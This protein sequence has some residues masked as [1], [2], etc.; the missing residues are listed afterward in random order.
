M[1]TD[2]DRLAVEF[3]CKLLQSL[4]ASNPND[5]DEIQRVKKQIEELSQKLSG[6]SVAPGLRQDPSVPTISDPSK[7]DMEQ[8]QR[9]AIH[10]ME[11][12]KKR[13]TNGFLPA[14][15]PNLADPVIATVLKKMHVTIS[16]SVVGATFVMMV[17]SGMIAQIVNSDHE[18]T[19]FKIV[20][21]SFGT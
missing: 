19:G 5:Q 12:L 4:A 6:H 8:Q 18:T 3:F 13:A 20:K 21:T 16:P 15:L 9:V 17:E 14:A 2:N 7:L 11:E 1:L 10:L